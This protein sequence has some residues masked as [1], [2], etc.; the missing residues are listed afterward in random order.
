MDELRD[1]V[2]EIVLKINTHRELYLRN[3]EAVKQ[4]LI[5]HVFRTLGWEWDNPFEVRPEEKTEDGRADYAL[6]LDGN[7]FAYVEAKN[8]GVNIIK[9]GKPLRQ[10]GRYCFNTGVRYGILTNGAVW[11]VLKAFEEGSRLSDRI[12]LKVNLENEPLERSTLKLSLLS[13]ARIREIEKLSALLKAFELSFNGLRNEGFGEDVLVAYLRAG[14]S[15][16]IPV[17]KLTGV[18]TPRTAYVN[19]NGWKALPLGEQSL[20]GVLF[21]VLMYLYSRREGAEKEEIKRVYEHLR[22][23]RL[24][25]S[26]ILALLKTIEE[27]EGMNIAVEL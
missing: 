17:D 20:R 6:I 16:L 15:S 4:H 8:L 19:E 14:R 22:R 25:P 23:I 18:E 10:L 26:Q 11:I 13:K 7:V 9:N 2:S 5:G 3:E 27:E 24:E 1:T 12:L 21:A